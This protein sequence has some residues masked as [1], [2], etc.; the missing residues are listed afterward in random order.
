MRYLHR[1]L[2]PEILDEVQNAPVVFS[3]VRSR[4]DRQPRCMGQCTSWDCKRPR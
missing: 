2:E 1:A 4:I 3:Y